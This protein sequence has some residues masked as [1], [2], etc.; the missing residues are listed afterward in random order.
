MSS[1]YCQIIQYSFLTASIDT[2]QRLC[3][4]MNIK[5]QHKDRHTFCLHGAY[6]L[7][8]QGGGT[9]L[10]QMIT[11]TPYFIIFKMQLFLHFDISEIGIPLFFF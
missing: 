4:V 3:H 1:I 9:T 10:N 2:C 7:I 8:G 11:E 5:R 6:S